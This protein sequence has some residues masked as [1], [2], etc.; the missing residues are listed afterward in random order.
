MNLESGFCIV[1]YRIEL[2]KHMIYDNIPGNKRLQV[3][4]LLCYAL[5]W[6]THPHHTVNLVANN[7]VP[8][9]VIFQCSCVDYAVY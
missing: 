5:S 4:G 6:L 9:S 2:P 1:Q 8:I 7:L 3:Q